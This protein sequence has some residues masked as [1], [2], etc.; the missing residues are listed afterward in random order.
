MVGNLFLRAFDRADRIYAAMLSRGYDGETRTLPMPA[1]HASEW[2]VLLAGL[3]V[4][5]LLALSGLLLYH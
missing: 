2:I 4:L 1:L 3:S 5:V